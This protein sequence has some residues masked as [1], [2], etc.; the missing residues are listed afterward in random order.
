[1]TPGLGA[2]SDEDVDPALTSIQPEVEALVVDGRAGACRCS[3]VSI[4]VCR[5]LIG[6]V[7][8]DKTPRP[9]AWRELERSLVQLFGGAHA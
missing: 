6:L 5:R 8:A 7:R 2:L 1:M 4:D 9:A 3:I